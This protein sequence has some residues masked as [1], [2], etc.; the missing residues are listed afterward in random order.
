MLCKLKNIL[1]WCFITILPLSGVKHARLFSDKNQTSFPFTVGTVCIDK[2]IYFGAKAGTLKN[3]AASCYVESTDALN[4]FAPENIKLNGVEQTNPLYD[5]PIN[6]IALFGKSILG[7]VSTHEPSKLYA[8]ANSITEVCSANICDAAGEPNNGIVA[9]AG[10]DVGM[11]V[12]IKGHGQEVFGAGDS[13]IALVLYEEKIEEKEVSEKEVEEFT[14]AL[15][16]NPEDEKAK[17]AAQSITVDEKKKKKKKIT[18]RSLRQVDVVPQGQDTKSM[19]SIHAIPLNVSS[20]CLKIGNDLVGIDNVVMRW[21]KSLNRLYIGIS[22]RGNSGDRDGVCAVIAGYRDQHGLF[23]FY[24]VI[25]DSSLTPDAHNEVIAGLGKDSCVTIHTME[26]MQTTTALDY[27]IVQGGNGAGGQTE[28][29]VFA[30]PLVN[31]IDKKGMLADESLAIHG[32]IASLASKVDEGF[33]ETRSQ[34]FLGRHLVEP[35]IEQDQMPRAH[36][37]A[38]CIGGGQLQAGPITQLFTKD[39]AVCAVVQHPDAGYAAG[40]YH[41]QAILGVDGA[42]VAWTHWKN[43]YALS[44]IQGAMLLPYTGSV[45]AWADDGAATTIIKSL[46]SKDHTQHGDSLVAFV[47]DLCADNDGVYA[48]R[49]WDT[50]TPGVQE[51]LLCFGMRE[52]LLLTCSG[53]EPYA[54]HTADNGTLAQ[55]VDATTHGVLFKCGDLSKIGPLSCIEILNTEQG[56]W[57]FVGGMHGVAVLRHEDGSGCYPGLSLDCLRPG[58]SF[59]KCLDYSGVRKLIADQGFLYVLCDDALERVEVC[60]EHIFDGDKKPTLAFT[61]TVLAHNSRFKICDFSTTFT[62]VIVSDTCAFLAHT[63]GLLRV[64]NGKDVKKDDLHSLDWTEV[65]VENSLGAIVNL[66][67]ISVTGREQDLTRYGA[68][69]LYVISGNIGKDAARLHRFVILEPEN[70]CITDDL[71]KPLNDWKIKDMR[72]GWVD[73][74]GFTHLFATDG[75]RFFSAFDRK[76]K[77][78]PMLIQGFKKDRTVMPLNVNE[79]MYIANMVQH[80]EYGFWMIAGDFG[81][82]VND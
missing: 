1:L 32:R 7:V 64:G 15:A 31:R 10:N 3:Y 46:W 47:N 71:I 54:V 76:K 77:V 19:Q 61:K 69:Q 82:C 34:L 24:P 50:K 4:P 21:S 11:Y 60:L 70:G 73:L 16:K 55:V 35:A 72:S 81:L 42:I 5:C 2:S 37:R 48:L 66:Y 75:M 28:R 39:D 22:A 79:S 41:S 58:L 68:C 57:L 59:V 45:L 74:S 26:L 43:I 29:S 67:P 20:E 78:D 65:L 62:D 80:P 56:T 30:L 63:N 51:P 23:V 13:G 6:H 8:I 40:I 25:S 27:L 36:D 49:V 18:T 33:R 53:K 12:A 38:V 44:G 17:A 14:R 52:S 9:I